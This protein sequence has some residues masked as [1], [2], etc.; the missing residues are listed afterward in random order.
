MSKRLLVT[1]GAGF[2][3]SNLVDYFNSESPEWEIIVIDDLSTG[4]HANLTSSTSTLVVE[5][6]LDLEA[7]VEASRKVDTIVHLAAIGSVPRSV[8][9]PRPTHDAN[10]T[11]SFNVLEAARIN[12]VKHVVVA[13]SSAVYGSNPGLPRTES[14]W[15]RPLSPYAA[16]KLATEAYA[17][18]FSSSYGINTLAFRF[19]NVYGPRQRADH[20]YAAVIPQFI[21]GFLDKKPLTIFGDGNQSRDFTYVD[22]ICRAIHESCERSLG[23]AGPVN[24]AFG[25][26]T[27][28]NELIL[29]L[30]TELETEIQL[31][32]AAARFGDVYS[33]QADNSLLAT[34]LPT[35]GPTPLVDGLRSTVDWFKRNQQ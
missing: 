24:L 33:S 29:M 15:T 20:P 11:G 6:I 5:S 10:I 21:S 14:D 23:H 16:S 1:G 7:L 19:F 22:S 4:L 2:I 17:S 34:L 3:G 12:N 35:I 26:R 32:F 27:T 30:E 8:S 31:D 28:L 25:S 13:S 9:E 18:A